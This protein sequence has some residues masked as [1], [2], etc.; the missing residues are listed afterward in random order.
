MIP[1]AAQS[2]IALPEDMEGR[3]VNDVY[4]YDPNTRMQYLHLCFFPLKNQS[5]VLAF[6]HKRDKLYRSLRH[7]INS[8]SESKVL[9]YLNYLMFAHT[10]NYFISKSIQQEIESNESLQKLSQ[11]A[12]GVPTMGY[13]SG[14]NN[15]GVGYVPVNMDD[16][17]NFLDNK[18]A[19]V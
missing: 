9:K 1:I 3:K 8:S 17:P 6:Y 4:N 5:V 7:Q 13:L 15:F 19:V 12:N 2:A 11:E 10:E 14:D 16:I 18:W